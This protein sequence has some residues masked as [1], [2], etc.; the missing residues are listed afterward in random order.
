MIAIDNLT[1][2]FGGWTLFDEISFLVN[3]KDRIGLVGK[4]GAGKTTLLRIITGEQQATSGAVT[5]NS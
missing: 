2:S 5:R 4:N 1:V 3:P